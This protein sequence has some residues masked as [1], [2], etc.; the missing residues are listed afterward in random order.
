MKILDQVINLQKS[1]LECIEEYNKLCG[2]LQEYQNKQIDPSNKDELNHLLHKIQKKYHEM[3][4]ALDLIQQWHPNATSTIKEYNDFI[5]R[6]K[7]AGATQEQ[8]NKNESN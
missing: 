4:P 5:E 6:L 1:L 7:K 2:K 3:F 8:M